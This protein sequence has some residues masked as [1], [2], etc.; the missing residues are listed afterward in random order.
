VSMSGDLGAQVA[1]PWNTGQVASLNAYQDSGVFRGC[2]CG[3]P[4]CPA[5]AR[6]GKG[7]LYATAAGWRCAAGGCGYTQ[8]WALQVMTGW[9]W[10]R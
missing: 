6:D 9:S 2:T 7:V 1:A 8:N 5:L 10:R 4:Q 3:N